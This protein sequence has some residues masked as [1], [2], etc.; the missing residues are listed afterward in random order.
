MIARFEEEA[1]D[2]WHQAVLYYEDQKE[3]LGVE[4]VEAVRQAV[5]VIAAAPLSWPTYVKGTRAYRL[6][7]FP[8][9]IIYI[10]ENDEVA[11][12]AVMH[13]KRSDKYWTQRRQK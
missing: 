12:L 4:F 6:T 11:V 7:G 1:R 2:D 3:G 10:V 9:R 5:Q 8:Y 13:T